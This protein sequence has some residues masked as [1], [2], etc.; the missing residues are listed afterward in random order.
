MYLSVNVL[1][2]QNVIPNW[3]I[4]YT[5]I[6]CTHQAYISE[7]HSRYLSQSTHC[8]HITYGWSCSSIQRLNVVQ[9][10]LFLTIAVK[11]LAGENNIVVLQR[12]SI[13]V[14]THHPRKAEGL[15]VR[16][17]GK[18]EERRW[19]MRKGRR[20]EEGG[21]EREGERGRGKERVP[22]EEKGSEDM[23]ISQSSS[24]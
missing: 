21:R 9:D 1:S 23:T 14:D 24:N 5:H 18:E 3:V 7:Y 8:N 2:L 20:G 10:T 11:V 12:H 16:G 15:K 19:R 13:L 17:G 22:R 4:S 6:A